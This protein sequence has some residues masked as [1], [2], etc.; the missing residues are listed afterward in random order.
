[1]NSRSCVNEMGVF[2]TRFSIN[3]GTILH[4]DFQS[5]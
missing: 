5:L 1:V 4:K 3:I 2:P